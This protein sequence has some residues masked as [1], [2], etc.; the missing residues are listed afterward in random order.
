MKKNLSNFSL[1]HAVVLWF[2]VFL[3]LAFSLSNPRQAKAAGTTLPETRGV[4]L[5]VRSIPRNEAEIDLIVDRLHGANF[6]TIFVECFYI[7]ETIY[8]S[9]YL[10]SLGMNRQRGA[11]IGMDPLQALLSSARKRGMSVHAWL[12]LFYIGLNEP[13]PVLAVHPEWR[14]INRDGTTGYRRGVN[15][16]YWICPTQPGV[17]DFY[18]GLVEEL[19]THY[20]IDGV[21]IDYVEIPDLS[22]ADAGYSE[23]ARNEFAAEHGVDPL[24]LDPY[25][26]PQL[27]TQWI[28]YRTEQVT[29]VVA[30]I[31]ESVRAIRPDV[32]ISA[33][34][35]PQGMPIERNPSYFQDWHRWAENG[36]IDVVIP[37][38]YSSRVNEMRG[39][40][41]WVEHF[42]RG[43]APYF[44]GL[45]AY[46][47]DSPEDLTVQVNAARSHNPSGVV[48]FAWPYL[49][50]T[51]LTLLRQV[52]FPVPAFPLSREDLVAL[53]PLKP[54]DPVA[55]RH[56]QPRR[57]EARFL[58]DAPPLDAPLSHPAW[59]SL[60]WQGE[61][62]LI[63]GEGA[64]VEQSIVAAGYDREHLYI[65]LP[66]NDAHPNTVKATVTR[67]DG[68]VFY[69]D[70]IE[71]FLDPGRTLSFYYQLAVNTLE[72]QY[73]SYSRVGPGWN[74]S[75]QARVSRAETGWTAILAVPF[76]ELGRE[77][78]R[79]GEVWGINF[80]RTMIRTGEFSGWSYTPGTF[81]APSFFGE[82]MFLE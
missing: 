76:T 31:A 9:P 15:F 81:H 40:L 29:A 54:S 19:V 50:D 38:A 21:Q 47:L 75:W 58:R 62:S 33:S 69:D 34:I 61:F 45:Q 73:D 80:N 59:Q 41:V 24:T 7:G 60:S 30:G 5:D 63:T 78:P 53:R 70:S 68:P 10:E 44:A 16:F 67:R 64:A 48:V 79:G 26:H 27:Y 32:I 2:L 11:F 52:S 36:Y 12:H 43:S 55:Y 22:R 71:V 42:L 14:S 17:V 57:I 39:M 20:P 56:E 77:T 13:G 65:V 3:C 28:R 72:T 8:P 46:R 37:M 82:I 66:V 18:R 4:W 49:T 6:N 25:L 23:F 51:S 35:M 1:G 74:G